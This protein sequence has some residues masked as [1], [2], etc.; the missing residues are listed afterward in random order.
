MYLNYLEDH[1]NRN[2]LRDFDVGILLCIKLFL[3]YMLRMY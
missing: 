3:L 1:F 2:W